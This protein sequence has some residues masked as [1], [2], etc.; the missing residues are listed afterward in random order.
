MVSPIPKFTKSPVSR[1]LALTE[2]RSCLQEV[3]SPLGFRKAEGQ[4]LR[5]RDSG[6]SC[7]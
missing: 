2:A 4:T 7:R 5:V 6:M 1:C 3:V